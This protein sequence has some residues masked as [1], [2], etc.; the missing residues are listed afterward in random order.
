MQKILKSVCAVMALCITMCSVEFVSAAETAGVSAGTAEGMQRTITAQTD[1]KIF[2][3]LYLCLQKGWYFYQP[4]LVL[5][6]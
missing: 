1:F 4:F 6:I 3:I 5:I 2:C